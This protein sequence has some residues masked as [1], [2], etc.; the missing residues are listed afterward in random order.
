M[1]RV[2]IGILGKGK[3]E[4]AEYVLNNLKIETDY[5]TYAIKSLKERQGETYKKTVIFGTTEASWEYIEK[6]L[7]EAERIYIPE[8][9]NEEE[10]KKMFSIMCSKLQQLKDYNITLDLTHGFRLQPFTLLS[11][12]YYLNLL[13]Y[14]KI[15]EIYYAFLTKEK[16]KN[17]GEIVSILP[18]LKIL[19]TASHINVYA[20]TL[21]PAGFEETL[22]E[23]EEERRKLGNQG[24][25]NEAESFTQLITP[26]KIIMDLSTNIIL[27]NPQGIKDKIG[28]AEEKLEEGL[29]TA[30]KLYPYLI[31]SLQNLLELLRKN[32]SVLKG[33][34]LWE[35]QIMLAETCLNHDRYV[36]AA[37][38]LREGIL[39][40]FCHKISGCKEKSCVKGECLKNGKGREYRER[41]T[42]D[43]LTKVAKKEL[44]PQTESHK[45]AS[46]L[47]NK[48]AQERNKI[49]HGLIGY[50]ETV[51]K[52][53]IE[54]KL[55][56]LIQEIKEKLPQI[57]F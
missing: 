19:K 48:V 23:L 28:K 33:K 42:S 14:I 39:T 4:T 46:K 29:K 40:Y 35:T 7:P 45:E 3:W 37:I 31:P 21:S 9:K 22:K 56:E 38:N 36:S 8:G 57:K 12:A 15:E 43:H 49:C 26:I 17:R 30:N 55:K 5:T 24:K 18:L 41:I 13:R 27:N 53:E 6:Y 51:K 25:I 50:P 16:D 1:D 20:K 32:L 2:L 54:K 10:F 52:E 47:F 44:I 11:T 34:T